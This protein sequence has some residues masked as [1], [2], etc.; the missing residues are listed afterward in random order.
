MGAVTI[1]EVSPGREPFAVAD[2]PVLPD[3][4]NRR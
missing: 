1:A 3:T 2:L 4:G